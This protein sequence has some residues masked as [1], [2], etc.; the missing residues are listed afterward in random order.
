MW[1]P[2]GDHRYNF[3]DGVL[4]IE[5]AGEFT[6]ADLDQ[7]IVL[8]QEIVTV[9]PAICLVVDVSAGVSASAEVRKRA[10]LALR[11]PNVPVFIAIAGANWAV[12]TIFALFTNAQQL[13]TGHRAKT[14]FSANIAQAS[15]WMARQRAE[16]A[17]R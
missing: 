7:Y 5:T 4:H 6:S 12:R 13:I 10:S 2:L 11:H 14:E 8:L 1:R 15:A 17:G 16:L 9:E 3:N